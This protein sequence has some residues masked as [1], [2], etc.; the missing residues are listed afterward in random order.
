MHKIW[1]TTIRVTSIPK[2]LFITLRLVNWITAEAQL[3]HINVTTKRIKTNATDVAYVIAKVAQPKYVR[4]LIRKAYGQIIIWMCPQT[5]VGFRDS[6]TMGGCPGA[7]YFYRIKTCGVF[8]TYTRKLHFYHESHFTFSCYLTLRCSYQAIM[9]LVFVV[10]MYFESGCVDCVLLLL[11]ISE[12]Y[13]IESNFWNRSC[14]IQFTWIVSI[15]FFK[16]VC[17][18]LFL[19]SSDSGKY[20]KHCHEVATCKS[21]FLLKIKKSHSLPENFQAPAPSKDNVYYQLLTIV[22]KSPTNRLMHS[23]MRV[24]RSILF[25]VTIVLRSVSLG[26]VQVQGG[27]LPLN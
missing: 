24:S 13:L 20:L 22:S 18:C 26:L 7:K 6:R 17:W 5:I 19:I 23:L 15:N 4:S 2:H 25:N 3:S 16:T 12:I 21:T 8:C 27:Y 9:F 1:L 11:E 10:S 14:C